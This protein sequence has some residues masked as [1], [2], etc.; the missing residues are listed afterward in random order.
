MANY[1]KS[2]I[3]ELFYNLMGYYPKKEGTAYEIISTAVLSFIENKDATHNQFLIGESKSQYQL[4]GLIGGDTIIEAKD[5]TKRNEKVGRDDLQKMQGALT[6]LPQIK[7][8]YFTSATK[9]TEP[10]QKYAKGS[11]TNSFQKEIVPIELRP[12]TAEDKKGRISQIN[13]S[14]EMIS[15]NFH[16]GKYTILFSDKERLKFED[17]LRESGQN[18]IHLQIRNFYNSKGEVIETIENISKIQ[19]PKF[20]MDATEVD[21]V[22]NTSSFIK[23]KERLFAINGIKYHIPIQHTKESFTIESSGNAIIL[24]KSE[25]LGV[26]KLITDND[27]K[28]AINMVLKKS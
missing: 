11:S 10:A 22:F 19:F 12:S 13:I 7:K 5:Y 25:A 18:E 15:P 20:P 28:N 2:P 17:Y 21:G 3:D 9:Y 23:I 16:K 24:V 14:L 8:G 27:M 6:D 26:N 1:R 4:D